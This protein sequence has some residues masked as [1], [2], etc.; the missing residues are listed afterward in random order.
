V[1]PRSAAVWAAAG[2]SEKKVKALMIRVK[3][4]PN[5]PTAVLLKRFKKACDTEKLK[6]AMKRVAYYEKPSDKARRKKGA[7]T[8]RAAKPK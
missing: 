2:S 4:R 6:D 3:A 1:A 5:E 8:R 7:A